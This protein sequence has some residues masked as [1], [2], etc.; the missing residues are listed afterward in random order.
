MHFAAYPG[1]LSST[2]DICIKCQVNASLIQRSRA[3]RSFHHIQISEKFLGSK[4]MPIGICPTCKSELNLSHTKSKHWM[5][6]VQDD[7]LLLT[8][9]AGQR[10]LLINTASVAKSHILMIA[11]SLK[12]PSEIKTH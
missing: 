9:L 10:S 6:S 4:S 8:H 7:L 2:I 12:I 3:L 11:L 5:Y 1:W